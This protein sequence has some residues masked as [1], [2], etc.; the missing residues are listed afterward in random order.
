[1]A[2]YATGSFVFLTLKL[3]FVDLF[4]VTMSH[5]VMGDTSIYKRLF[6]EAGARLC[7]F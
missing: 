1:V 6:A 7:F 3:V 5:R 4:C 2:Q